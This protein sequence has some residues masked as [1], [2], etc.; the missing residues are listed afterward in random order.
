[1]PVLSGERFGVSLAAGVAATLATAALTLPVLVPAR[2]TAPQ[3]GPVAAA[4]AAAV[5]FAL[6][7]PP[8]FAPADPQG[9][10]QDGAA[11]ALH[12]QRAGAEIVIAAQ[13]AQRTEVARLL[14]TATGVDPH[15]AAAALAGS[16]P[17]TLHWRGTDAAEAWRLVLGNQTGHALQ[18]VG[19]RCRLWLSGGLPDGA[20]GGGGGDGGANLP[21]ALP[22]AQDAD[23]E[24]AMHL[25]GDVGAGSEAAWAP[26]QPDPPGLFP[27]D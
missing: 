8:Q 6:V 17:L 3:D 12:V 18:C 14:A 13:G 26:T 21:S 11:P 24:G 23:T 16:R 2:A 1:M 10:A 5:G 22:L 4:P 7:A 19:L 20:K 25:D 9:P 15:T 27:T